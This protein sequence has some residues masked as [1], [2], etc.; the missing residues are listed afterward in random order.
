MEQIPHSKPWI[1]PSDMEAVASVLE[2][3]MLA[4]G[5]K[6]RM[7]EMRVAS[8]V[9]ATDAV[10]VGCGAAAIVLALHGLSI[11]RGDEVVLPTY[12]CP[13]V[14]EA[15]FSVG[16]APVFC[17]VGQN[18]VMTVA[19]VEQVVSHKTRAIIVPHMYGIFAEVE[20]LRVLGVPII[21]DCAQALD[22]YGARPTKADVAVFSFHPTKCLTAGEGGM[23][24]SSDAAILERMRI[25]RD[26]LKNRYYARFFSP[27][28]DISAALALSQLERYEEALVRRR[29]IAAH[30]VEVLDACCPAVINRDALKSSMFFR[31]PLRIQCD[32]TTCQ[33]AFLEHGI[34]VRK[35]VDQLLHR[36]MGRY[37]YEFPVAAELFDTTLSIPIYPALSSDE[38]LRCAEALSQVLPSL[39]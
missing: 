37:D 34:H 11:N 35:G 33:Q 7:L 23:A 32:F 18:W 22:S 28:S 10:G 4:Q 27:I 13:S 26:G 12:V 29:E 8:W 21:E 36:G 31:F 3:F 1:T 25:Y 9:N 19:D 24:A 38:E 39:H 6:T 2:S 17:D 30:Y 15:I 16:A 14:L 5:E 20:S